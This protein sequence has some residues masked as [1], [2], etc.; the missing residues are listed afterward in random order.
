VIEAAGGRRAVVECGLA[1]P[2]PEGQRSA[3]AYAL[4]V[5]LGLEGD[6]SVPG[7]WRYVNERTALL[8]F[9]SVAFLHE[10]SLHAEG[11]T[12]SALDQEG[13]RTLAPVILGLAGP[14]AR[15]AP[16]AAKD[17][18]VLVQIRNRSEAPCPAAIR[19]ARSRTR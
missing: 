18:W 19:F 17:G 13:L 14:N 1:Y 15:T 3:L 9:P 6:W 11:F 12:G 7:V 4:D 10:P 2:L 16:I 5:R 8:P